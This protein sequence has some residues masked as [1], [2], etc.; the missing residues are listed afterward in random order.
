MALT[1]ED[2]LEWSITINPDLLDTNSGINTVCSGP[3]DVSF[4]DTNREEF[5][6]ENE[7]GEDIEYDDVSSDEQKNENENI[8]WKD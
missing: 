4:V 2:D 7:V 8:L 3:L 1:G 5:Y 6:N